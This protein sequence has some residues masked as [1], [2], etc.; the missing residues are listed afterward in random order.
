M[1][2]PLILTL[3]IDFLGLVLAAYV[4]WKRLKDDFPSEGIFS[5]SLIILIMGLLLGRLIYIFSNFERFGLDYVSWFSLEKAPGF[6]LSGIF[7]T[8]IFTL[9]LYSLKR[10]WDIWLVA[11]SFLLP[12]L[13]TVLVFSLSDLVLKITLARLAVV[14]LIFLDLLIVRRVGK[15]Y[16]SFPWY[17]SGK[18][19][20]LACFS[21]IA[22]FG[23]ILV[24]D[25]FLKS[26]LYSEEYL[27][28]LVIVLAAILLYRRSGRSLK[29]DRSSL[30]NFLIKKRND[31]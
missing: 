24:L 15:N 22:F 27:N 17:K 2:L 7:L 30:V 19:G 1:T 28:G 8:G 3:I 18:V 25:I 31:G 23:P 12:F 6:S 16:R 11:D 10:K 4:F 21:T 14:L 20:F 29:E 5:L 9:G 26:G 13:I